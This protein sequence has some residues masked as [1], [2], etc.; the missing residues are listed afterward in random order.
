MHDV[1]TRDRDF[2]GLLLLIASTR[3]N[4]LVDRDNPRIV[5]GFDSSAEWNPP[6]NCFIAFEQLDNITLLQRGNHL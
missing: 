2:N 1:T 5:F 6:A 3:L 4:L